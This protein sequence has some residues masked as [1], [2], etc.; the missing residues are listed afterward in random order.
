M[1]ASGRSRY[2]NEREILN[3]LVDE[4]TWEVGYKHIYVC[5]AIFNVAQCLNKILDQ[6]AWV[7][8]FN[9]LQKIA[10]CVRRVEGD[11][12]G[13]QEPQ[14][15][16]FHVIGKRVAENMSRYLPKGVT[17]EQLRSTMRKSSELSAG[18][19]EGRAEEGK[20]REEERCSEDPSSPFRTS[21]ISDEEEKES[22]IQ[23]IRRF[24]IKTVTTPIV[25][26]PKHE[27]APAVPLKL[28]PPGR[29]GNE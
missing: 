7:H 25:V 19:G 12:A 11:M 20:N 26:D 27:I 8:V 29:F 23:Q 24:S 2:A 9:A 22:H 16:N 18:T 28:V 4:N 3:A 14:P 10:A 5:N 21:S 13:P 1:A 17:P 15:L 6:K